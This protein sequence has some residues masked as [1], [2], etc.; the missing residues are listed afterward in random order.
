MLTES[1]TFLKNNQPQIF[2][3]YEVDTHKMYIQFKKYVWDRN[4]LSNLLKTS[5]QLMCFMI[6][7]N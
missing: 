4:T 7:D 1:A 3:E 5:S 2:S 6:K